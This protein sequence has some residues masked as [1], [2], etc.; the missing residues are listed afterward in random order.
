[1]NQPAQPALPQTTRSPGRPRLPRISKQPTLARTAATAA[2]SSDAA[3]P[4]GLQLDVGDF[5]QQGQLVVELESSSFREAVIRAEAEW[6]VARA[7]LR[8]RIAEQNQAQ[9]ELDRQIL[10]GKSGVVTNQQREEAEAAVA[11]A[12]A[13]VELE[14]ANV[15]RAD[16][17]RSQAAISLEETRILAGQSGHVAERFAGVG[18]LAAPTDPLLRIVN[19]DTVQTVVRVAERDYPRVEV[20]QEA[21]IFVDAWPNREF[22][23]T[24]VRKSPVLD[25]E[26]RTGELQVEIPNEGYRLRPGMHA[27]VSIILE[28]H[29]SVPLVPLAALVGRAEEQHVYSVRGTPA[30]TWKTAIT[31]G[32]TDG[33][34]IEILDG[35][36][37]D[38]LVVTL[39]NRLVSD[40]QEVTVVEQTASPAESTSA[41]PAADGREPAVTESAGPGTDRPQTPQPASP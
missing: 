27:K 41:T 9:K 17:E 15:A 20:G 4:R 31:T 16:S 21:S 39:G 34:M 35:L 8:A 13:Q 40:G 37:A 28:R 29:S 38:S 24:V 5:V 14:K 19:I 1:M 11:I 30:K 6:N 23:G 32:I 26:T 22:R 33:T 12:T 25:P 3:P 36:E 7:Q 10:L 2:S 18:D